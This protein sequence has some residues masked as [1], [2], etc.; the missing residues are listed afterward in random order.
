MPWRQARKSKDQ[1]FSDGLHMA[2]AVH[3]SSP[4]SPGDP[5]ATSLHGPPDVSVLVVDDDEDAR[6]GIVRL[7]QTFGM[8]RARAA[9]DGEEALQLLPDV[10]PDLI[11]CDLQMPRL[12]GFEFVRRL[13]RTQPFHRILTV[14]VTGLSR[15]IDIEATRAAGFDGHLVKPITGE[16]IAR[17]LE[18]AVDARRRAQPPQGA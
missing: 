3:F 15:A 10:Q 13:R 12:D 14:A 4:A 11:L 7:I 2:L 18:R 1:P 17:L 5:M 16:M 9:R 8:V 6:E